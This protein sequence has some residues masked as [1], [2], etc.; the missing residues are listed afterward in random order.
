MISQL[1]LVTANKARNSVI[2]AASTAKSSAAQ[3]APLLAEAPG[4]A[5]A[6]IQYY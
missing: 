3:K 4:T 6:N 2:G 5:Q 1:T